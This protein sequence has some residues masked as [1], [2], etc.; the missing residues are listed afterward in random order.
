MGTKRVPCSGTYQ[1]CD[2]EDKPVYSFQADGYCLDRLFE[3]TLSPYGVSPTDEGEID[4][5]PNTKIQ[6][7]DGKLGALAG[8]NP[9]D[10]I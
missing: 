4:K 6:A 2:Q 9:P 8:I 1:V 3:G 10:C 5:H 7:P